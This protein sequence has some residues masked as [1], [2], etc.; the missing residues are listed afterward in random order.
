MSQSTA[1]EAEVKTCLNPNA[2]YIV[3]NSSRNWSWTVTATTRADSR[4]LSKGARRRLSWFEWHA[5]KGCSIA[6]TC[7]HFDISRPTFYRWRERLDRLGLAGLEDRSHRPHQARPATWTSA[8]LSA[9]RRVRE[10]HPC[11]GKM[12]IQVALA[13]EGIHLSAS[14]IGRMLGQLKRRNL[15]REPVRM[16]KRKRGRL[17]PRPWARRKPREWIAVWPGDLVQIDAKDVRPI[18]GKFFKHLSLV[19]VASRYAAAEVGIGAKAATMRDHLDRMLS[20]LP[21]SV[22]AIQIDGGSEFKA[23]FEGY[24]KDKAIELFVLPPRSPKLNGCVERIQRT[25]DEE[26]YQCT[27]AELRVEPLRHAL[28]EY[29]IVYNTVRPHQALKYKTPQEY[30]EA[31]KVAA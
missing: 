19:D 4:C 23:E 1:S 31:R 5:A 8:Q 9:I 7:R 27:N 25:F 28:H 3:V 24:C 14:M 6:Q 2:R 21:F 12:K 16:Q 26:F 13:R 22:A 10:V 15:L 17:T 30:L 18:P 11:W 29:E 20:R